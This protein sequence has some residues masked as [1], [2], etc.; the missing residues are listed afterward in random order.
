MVDLGLSAHGRACRNSFDA[1]E[2]A[3]R[4]GAGL[5]RRHMDPS[6][7][8]ADEEQG[9][10]G[11]RGLR[12]SQ[13]RLGRPS[14]NLSQE[15]DARDPH[16]RGRVGPLAERRDLGSRQ[17]P[18]AS[19]AGR[20]AQNRRCWSALRRRRAGPKCR[21]RLPVVSG[22]DSTA[23]KRKSRCL[24]SHDSFGHATARKRTIPRSDKSPTQSSPPA[25]DFQDR[26]QTLGMTARS[27]NETYRAD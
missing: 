22:G 14:E 25:A 8:R 12:L 23:P 15:G 13:N 10:G 3:E 18:A 20:N 26:K 27:P 17:I 5:L 11:D 7:L 1:G 2:L 4:P 9:L 21:R 6:R 19:V 16:D 24:Q